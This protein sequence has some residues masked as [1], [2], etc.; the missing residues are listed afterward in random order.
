MKGAGR[1]IAQALR[2]QAPDWGLYEADGPGSSPGLVRVRRPHWP[3]GKAIE[4]PASGVE[5]EAGTQIDVRFHNRSRQLPFAS[6]K[7]PSA[8]GIS[9][10]SFAIGLGIWHQSNYSSH[11]NALG[12]LVAAALYA[13]DPP[14]ISA[15]TLPTSDD[16]EITNAAPTPFGLVRYVDGAAPAY[17]TMWPQQRES[18]GNIQVC[19]GA[20]DAVSKTPLWQWNEGSYYVPAENFANQVPPCFNLFFT[21]VG[22]WIFAVVNT[23]FFT[24]VRIYSSN[25]TLSNVAVT[26]VGFGE[27]HNASIHAWESGSGESLAQHFHCF[28]PYFSEGPLTDAVVAFLDLNTTTG[29][30]TREATRTVAD[31]PVGGA[32]AVPD[33]LGTGNANATGSPAAWLGN[34]ALIFVS[35]GLRDGGEPSNFLEVHWTLRSLNPANGTNGTFAKSKTIVATSSPTLLNPGSLITE[36]AAHPIPIYYTD[37]G[38]WYEGITYSDDTDVAYQAIKRVAPLILP[39]AASN[40]ARL[41]TIESRMANDSL[42][43]PQWPLVAENSGGGVVVDEASTVWSVVIEPEQVLYGGE[44]VLED[45]GT[46]QPV[47]LVNL[48]VF[49]AGAGTQTGNFFLNVP[50]VSFTA[51]DG[52]VVTAAAEEDPSVYFIY[53]DEG[54]PI[55]TVSLSIG[56]G[57]ADWPVYTHRWTQH[58]GCLWHTILRGHRANGTTVEQEISQKIDATTTASLG[59]P[60]GTAVAV[61]H[62]D[63]ELADNM[64]QLISFA[65]KNLLAILRDLHADGAG[66]NPSPAIEI[67]EIGATTA[68]KL[69]TIR[70]GSYTEKFLTD[71]FAHDAWKA[72]DQV[73]DPYAFG[74]PRMK[75]CRKGGTFNTPVIVAMVGENKKVDTDTESQF[76]RVC[77]ATIE[78]NT[79][80]SPDVVRSAR[81]SEDLGVGN[82][83]YPA[84]TD[85]WGPIWDSW[86]TLVLTP[87]HVAWIKDSEFRET[88]V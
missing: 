77:Y 67:W 18:D 25:A 36:V 64:H 46:T 44:Y 26:L 5:S 76:K 54:D 23:A 34:E 19:A 22:G 35:G 7:V 9:Q 84:G 72:G 11:Q 28:L 43:N 55:Y 85:F 29:Q 13:M 10:S 75:A 2:G 38:I 68:T 57:N 41:G 74:P 39:V 4:I 3:A 65:D 87:D 32:A 52:H 33:L 86:D 40:L 88:T 49:V 63:L 37:P 66:N 20:W 71:D 50:T 69:S 73:W 61:T 62:P 70:L 42:G 56:Y 15:W 27:T 16:P 53:N 1:T 45:T 83:G 78:L 8:R 48:S 21:P 58:M 51:I 47:Y 81:T 82:S 60:F 24:F 80:A 59:K 31:L 17:A 30:W 6:R 14:T 12:G 79:P